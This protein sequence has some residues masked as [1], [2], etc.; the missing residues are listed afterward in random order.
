MG[1]ETALVALFQR[2]GFARQVS[3]AFLGKRLVAPRVQ[4]I[5]QIMDVASVSTSMLPLGLLP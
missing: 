2:T 1:M 3:A 5:I 4:T